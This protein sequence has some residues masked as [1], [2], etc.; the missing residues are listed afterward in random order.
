[1]NMY[2]S[3]VFVTALL[4][5]FASLTPTVG[6][7]YGVDV[8]SAVSP[9]DFRCLKNNGF[10]FVIVR[11]YQSLGKCTTARVLIRISKLCKP[12]CGTPC[13]PA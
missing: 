13:R 7:T 12:A 8:S 4:L 9:D 6:G 3:M 1:M 5:P 10:E 11:A 2:V